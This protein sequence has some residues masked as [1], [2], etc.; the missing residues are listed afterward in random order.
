M[1]ERVRDVISDMTVEQIV[2]KL[3]GELGVYVGP[4]ATGMAY[5]V[6]YQGK[7]IGEH[8]GNLMRTYNKA[9]RYIALNKMEYI[10]G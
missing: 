5:M 6:T 7:R 8:D 1:N 10:D 9:L 3:L 2:D 4:D